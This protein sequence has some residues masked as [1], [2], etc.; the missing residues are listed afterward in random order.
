MRTGGLS[1]DTRPGF[2]W[3]YS[4]SITRRGLD[5]VVLSRRQ[6]PYPVLGDGGRTGE[7]RLDQ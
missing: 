2:V 1:R 5:L 6:Q 4:F 7:V 3:R